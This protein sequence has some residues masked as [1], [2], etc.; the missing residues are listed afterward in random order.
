MKNVIN[1]I[2]I[3]ALIFFTCPIS[4]RAADYLEWNSDFDQISL[5]SIASRA[6]T[7][8]GSSTVTLLTNG[9]AEITA[10][11]TPGGPAELSCF[12]DILITEYRLLFSDDGSGATGGADTDYAEYDTFL[13]SAASVTYITDDNDV[14]VTLW[15]RASNNLDEVADSDTYNATQ[16]LTATWVE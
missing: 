10:D 7:R 4:I 11:N 2:V 14:D 3:P 12:T 1:Y 6:Q 16:T 15:I 5:L 8:E 9:N 13:S